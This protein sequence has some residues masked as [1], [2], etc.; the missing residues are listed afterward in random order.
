MNVAITDIKKHRNT[1]LMIYKGFTVDERA[2][3]TILS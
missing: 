3:N 2:L 1:A